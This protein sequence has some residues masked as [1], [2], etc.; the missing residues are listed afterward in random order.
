MVLKCPLVQTPAGSGSS[1]GPLEGWWGWCG[2][3]VPLPSLQSEAVR[4]ARCSPLHPPCT[5]PLPFAK[6]SGTPCVVCCLCCLVATAKHPFRPGEGEQ[7][8]AHSTVGST[9]IS[10]CFQIHISFPGEINQCPLTTSFLQTQGACLRW[11]LHFWLAFAHCTLGY[12][13]W[14]QPRENWL[15]L[16]FHVSGRDAAFKH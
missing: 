16:E 15:C 4:R 3:C 13:L 7:L 1:S 2:V 12:G 9:R 6:T 10:S 14:E 5:H 8:L 11:G